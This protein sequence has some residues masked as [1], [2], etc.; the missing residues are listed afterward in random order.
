MKIKNSFLTNVLIVV[1]LIFSFIY[2]STGQNVNNVAPDFSLAKLDGLDSVKLSDK[3]GKVVLLE[4]WN[5]Q[6]EQCK[7]S[8]PFLNRLNSKYQNFEVIA[9]NVDDDIDSAKAYADSLN[10]T[11]T[12]VYDKEKK[13]LEDYNAPEEMGTAYLIDQYGKVRYIHSGYNEKG[14]KK[15]EFMVRGFAD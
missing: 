6:C 12:I 4:F 2:I 8:L 5:T 15:L 3:R 10:F 11:M 14:K 9:I 13:V 1:L 7:L